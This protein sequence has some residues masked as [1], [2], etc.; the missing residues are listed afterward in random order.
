MSSRKD[1]KRTHPSQVTLT[2]QERL[3][4]LVPVAISAPF[5]L[6]AQKESPSAAIAARRLLDR[7]DVKQFIAARMAGRTAAEAT[8]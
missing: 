8:E 4:A 6:A 2:A 7:A 1:A 3:A 5:D